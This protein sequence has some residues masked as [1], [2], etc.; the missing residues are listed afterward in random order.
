MPEAPFDPGKLLRALVTGRVDFVLVG[1]QAGVMQGSPLPTRDVDVVPAPDADNLDRLARVLRSIDARIR[2]DRE[3]EGVNFVVEGAVLADQVVWN[4]TT[5][6]GALD[7][8]IGPPPGTQGYADLRRDA[9]P[10]ELE[11]GVTVWAAS[12]SDLIR[13]KEAAGRLKDQAALPALQALLEYQQRHGL[14]R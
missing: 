11:P 6:L 9:A 7:L 5:S 10:F 13:M 1:G 14:A 3:P 2:V 8:L 12:V 4:L